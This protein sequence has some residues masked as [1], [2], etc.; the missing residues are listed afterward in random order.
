MTSES[1]TTNFLSNIGFFQKYHNNITGLTGT[2]GSQKS[3][4]VLEEVYKV[5]LLRVPRQKKR[6]FIELPPEIC[7]NDSKQIEK[8][9][10]S[11]INTAQL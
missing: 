2:F 6:Q 9:C 1:F 5:D 11:A 8:I 7:E 4:K 10:E 3:Q